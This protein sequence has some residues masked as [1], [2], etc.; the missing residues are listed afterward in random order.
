MTTTSDTFE[1]KI[2][3]LHELVDGTD[4]EVIWND[5]IPDPDNPKQSRQ[6]DI[7]IKRGDALTLVECRIHS[8]RQDVKWI[9][10][11]IG[12]RTSL[13]AAAVIAVSASGFTEGAI[14]KAKAHGI[15]LR[16]LEQLTSGEIERWGC[17]I[18]MTIYYYQYSDLE[19]ALFFRPESISNLDMAVLA[20]E[21]K[22]YPGRQSL[23]NAAGD[24]LGKLKL[25]TIE[26]SQRQKVSFRIRLQLEDFHLC[27]EPVL[28][29][30]L[31]GAAKLIEQLLD[32][33]AVVAYRNPADEL[34]DH[35]II[36][37]RT[38]LGETG[39]MV[40]N[41]YRMATVLDLSAISLPPNCQFC[42]LQTAANKDLDMD[43]FE[44]LGS[45]GLY[46][47]GGP[48]TVTI[49]SWTNR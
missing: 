8:D 9:E 1:R 18:S 47:S 17:T 43:S 24:E 7:S 22:T 46:A 40:H 20:Q 49:H 19:L 34:V 4:A 41:A 16:D 33:P 5:R 23:F 30:E 14:L 28:E 25:L 3:R 35:S 48:M 42:Y 29:V 10:E 39:V 26:P 45:D 12:R 11:L 13:Q 32:V 44:I 2:H 6:I 36:M 31:S 15:F 21:L 38:S 37:Q 27:R